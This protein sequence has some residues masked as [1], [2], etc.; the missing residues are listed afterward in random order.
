[1]E[2][3]RVAEVCRWCLIFTVCVVECN[4]SNLLIVVEH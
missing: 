3:A 4:L 2:G 1:V